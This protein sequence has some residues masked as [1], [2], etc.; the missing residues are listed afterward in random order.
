MCSIYKQCANY[1]NNG[2][3]K[4]PPPK[5]GGG[6]P[7]AV[8]EVDIFHL[9]RRFFVFSERRGRRSLQFCFFRNDEGVVPS[10]LLFSERRGRRS[11]QFCFLRNDGGVVP[12]SFAFCGT[13]GASFPTVLFFRND[14]GVVPYSFAKNTLLIFLFCFYIELQKFKLLSSRVRGGYNKHKLQLPYRPL[15]QTQLLVHHLG[16]KSFS[17]HHFLFE[18]KPTE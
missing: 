5:N 18:H 14:G 4:Y 13:T 12:Y 16:L 6:G 11:L 1:K 7:L 9:Y 8:V 10:V 3:I 17:V 15:I 2:T